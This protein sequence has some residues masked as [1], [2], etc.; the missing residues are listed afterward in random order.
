MKK[1]ALI[2]TALAGFTSFN[3]TLANAQGQFCPW[4]VDGKWTA[5]QRNE[6]TSIPININLRQNRQFFSGTAFTPSV[7]S[8]RVNGN[9]NNNDFVMI[10]EWKNGIRAA[11]NGTIHPIWQGNTQTII[12]EGT[13][14][15]AA[16]PFT[17][18]QWWRGIPVWYHC[19]PN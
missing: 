6:G 2:I 3:S 4:W 1:I 14:Y 18:Y 13:S 15:D 7:G 9:V 16:N 10:I 12:L 17:R 5:Y 11:Y 8:G 19:Y